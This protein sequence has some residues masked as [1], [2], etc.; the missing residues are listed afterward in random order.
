MT[1]E[2]MNAY[3]QGDWVA[4]PVSGSVD[5]QIKARYEDLLLQTRLMGVRNVAT[6]H[7]QALG[8]VD[9]SLEKNR[10]TDAVRNAREVDTCDAVI[11]YLQREDPPKKHW[12]SLAIIAYAVGKGK[13]VILLAPRDCVVWKHHFVHHPGVTRLPYQDHAGA[14]LSGELPAK[15]TQS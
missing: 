11:T 1:R 6:W 3:V 5:E 13:Q 7:E 2:F 12:G 15:N 10:R 8:V 14:I 9:N 4:S